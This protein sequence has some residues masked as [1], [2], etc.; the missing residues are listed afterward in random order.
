M[1]LPDSL[2]PLTDDYLKELRTVWKCAHECV[3][4][5][6]QSM[7]ARADSHRRPS[8]FQV[9]DKVLIS[10]K[11][12]KM[13]DATARKLQHR[14]YGPYPV[15]QLCGENAVVVELYVV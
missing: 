7:K 2:S 15:L 11:V 8:P 6:Q 9:G 3:K 14:Y 1:I 4:A 5:A 13:P 12:L 10:Y